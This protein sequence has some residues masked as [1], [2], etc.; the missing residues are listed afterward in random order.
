V[1]RAEMKMSKLVYREA[2]TEEPLRQILAN[3]GK[4]RA[5]IVERVRSEKNRTLVT[6]C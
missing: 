6:T 1:N 3:A 4:E 5:V 2:C